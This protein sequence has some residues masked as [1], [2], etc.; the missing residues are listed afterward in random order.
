MDGQ[1]KE[2]PAGGTVAERFRAA[3]EERD[4]GA[5]A[6]AFTPDALLDANLPSWR[7]QRQGAEAI[8]RQIEE[9]FSDAPARFVE[10]HERTTEWGAVVECAERKV[11][12]GEEAYYRQVFLFF[13]EGDQ[14]ANFTFYCTGAWDAATLNRHAREAPMVRW[15]WHASGTDS[16]R[17]ERRHGT[18]CA[19]GGGT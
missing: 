10:W 13:T 15:Q 7:L 2:R 11:E 8:R 17:P 6:A 18:A 3:L 1:L 12:E 14:I 4:F 9:W 19:K 5:V 16:S